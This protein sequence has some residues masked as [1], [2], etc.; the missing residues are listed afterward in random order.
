MS[1]SLEYQMMDFLQAQKEQK[2]KE[3]LTVCNA[4]TER[5]GL[6][7]SEQDKHELILY[8][9]E[10]LKKHKRVEFG[11]GIL[12]KLIYAFCDSGFIDQNN[13]LEML[14]KL[15]DIFY[16]Y[17]NETQDQ[18]T[19]DELIHFMREQFEEV[20]F[21]DLAY[22]EGT[23]LARFATA[24]RS[25]YRGYAATDGRGEYAQFDEEERWSEEMYQQA[26]GELAGW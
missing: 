15:Q 11:N 22:L 14:E 24:V 25:G 26:M 2:E 7:L 19:D 6:I 4:K 3:L 5:F 8:R 23:C 21:G 13:Y 17:K 20:C 9:N 1:E 12:D 18:M 16:E 10:S